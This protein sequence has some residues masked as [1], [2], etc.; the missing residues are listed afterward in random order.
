MWVEIAFYLNPVNQVSVKAICSS[1]TVFFSSLQ[2]FKKRYFQLTQL[3]DNSYIMNFYKDEKISKEPK[4]CIFLDSC[5]GVIQVSLIL[6]HWLF[7][8]QVRIICSTQTNLHG[9]VSL[10]VAWK[11]NAVCFALQ[12]GANA[13]TGG[14]QDIQLKYD[15]RWVCTLCWWHT[16]EKYLNLC[17]WFNRFLEDPL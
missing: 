17:K 13:Q 10:S 2:S 15:R 1:T 9:W 12:I 14:I 11:E 6:F 7:W 4:G 5:T 3:S 16:R 8:C